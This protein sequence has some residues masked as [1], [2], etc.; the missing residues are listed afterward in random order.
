M[1]AD[2]DSPMASQEGLSSS[3]IGKTTDWFSSLSPSCADAFCQDSNLVKEARACYFTTHPWGWAHGNM[4]NLSEIFRELAQGTGLLGESIHELQWSWNG[5][6]DLKHGNYILQSLPKGLKFLRV[7]S[8][9]ESPKIMGLKRIH[10][11]D[12]LQ[13]FAS[14]TYCPWCG[15]IGQNKGTIVNHLRTIHYKLGLICNQCYS[16]PMVML[17]ALHQHGC[18]TCT[19]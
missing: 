13:H 17:D 8:A 19:N 12:A 9:K 3:K 2:E 1:S 5:L 16:C 15:K 14:F 10:D 11:S 4:D 6:E 18:H 7:V